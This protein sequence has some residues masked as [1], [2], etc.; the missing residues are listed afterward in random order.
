[1]QSFSLIHRQSNKNR[2]QSRTRAVPYQ[3]LA[4]TGLGAHTKFDTSQIRFCSA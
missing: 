2:N 3:G 1:M 4:D